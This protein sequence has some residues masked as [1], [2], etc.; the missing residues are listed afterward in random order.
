MSGD[1]GELNLTSERLAKVGGNVF[2]DLNDDSEY[3]IGEGLFNA[4][5]SVM[6]GSCMDSSMPDFDS[7]EY[8]LSLIHI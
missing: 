3:N 7:S 4:S 8:E 1:N 6:D 2:W 5:I